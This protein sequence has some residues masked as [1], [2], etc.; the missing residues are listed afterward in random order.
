MAVV[1]P[2]VLRVAVFCAVPVAVAVV[3][4]VVGVVLLVALG[5]TV[6]IQTLVHG[7]ETGQAEGVSTGEGHCS[8]GD[9]ET[10]GAEEVRR[11]L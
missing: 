10:H 11:G 7:L 9:M 1:A 8:G 2:W 4:V 6:A 5:T 3:V